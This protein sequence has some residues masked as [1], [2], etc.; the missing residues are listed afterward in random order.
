LRSDR[1]LIKRRNVTRD[2]RS[3]YRADRDFFQLILKSRDVAAAM[4][5][6]GLEHKNNTPTCFTIPE[7]ISSL[8]KLKKLD[9]LHE[10]A[11]IVV[12][13]FVFKGDGLSSMINDILTTQE[14]EDIINGQELTDDGCFPC[15]FQGCPFSFKFDGKSRRKHERT[16]NPPPVIEESTNLLITSEKPDME[17][18][19]KA[20]TSD[21][22]FNYNCAILTVI[23]SKLPGRCFRG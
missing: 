16:H 14:K 12:D 13:K 21:D 10:A 1:S 15:R 18:A 4:N 19:K 22:M 2:P 17:S 5:T 11:G 6:L 8:S 20:V 7:D 23:F 3:N 9:I